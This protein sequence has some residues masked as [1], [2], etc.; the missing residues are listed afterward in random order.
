[1]A[2]TARRWLPQRASNPCFMSATRFRNGGTKFGAVDSTP[3]P[4]GVKCGR[5]LRPPR[6]SESHGFSLAETRVERF[7]N[8]LGTQAIVPW[9]TGNRTAIPGGPGVGILFGG[10]KGALC[11]DGNR[12]RPLKILVKVLFSSLRNGHHRALL[13]R[14]RREGPPPPGSGGGMAV[15][16][17]RQTLRTYAFSSF[18]S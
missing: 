15:L 6:P 14:L 13:E 4:P 7:G 12:V 17:S 9:E 2:V 5:D 10:C 18:F 16:R 1:M 11:A 3:A 8:K